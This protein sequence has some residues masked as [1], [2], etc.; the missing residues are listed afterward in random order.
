MSDDKTWLTPSAHQKLVEEY[1][2]LTTTGRTEITAKIAEARDHGD[3]REN[4]EYHAAKDEQG[5][6]EARIRQIKHIL[7]NAV[8]REAEDDGT[9]SIGTVATV[10]DADGDEMEVFVANQE[11]KVRGLVLAS[12][13]SPLGAAL[14]GSKPGDEVS[15][16]APGGTFTVTV[17]DVRVYDG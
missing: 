10:L 6:Q 14:I 12:P 15:Y 7:D 1:E 11:N 13:E 5:M 4:A 17:K 16:E 8:I 3:L 2:H 9:V